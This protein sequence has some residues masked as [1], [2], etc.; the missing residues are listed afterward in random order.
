M[1]T[2]F[3]PMNPDLPPVDHRD[4]RAIRVEIQAIYARL[5]KLENAVMFHISDETAAHER[6]EKDRR[7]SKC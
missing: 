6:R 3:N 1:T 7:E 4:I 5:D 2:D